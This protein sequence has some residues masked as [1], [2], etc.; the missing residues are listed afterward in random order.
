MHKRR[1]GALL[2][3]VVTAL[4][5]APA[6]NAQA[7]LVEVAPCDDARLSKPFAPWLDVANYKLAP[8]G[9]FERGFGGWTLSRGAAPALGSEPWG[10]TGKVGTRALALPAGATALSPAT[11]VNAGSPTVRFFARSTGG[12]LPLLRVDAVY[13]DGL[14]SVAVP[15]GVVLPTSRWQ[16]S[17]PMLTGSV[18]TA[19]LAGGEVPM[20]LRFTAVRGT[21][22]VDDV[23]VDPYSRR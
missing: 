17:A 4:L 9:D 14:A 19:A 13:R 10:V 23:F 6:A 12:L 20:S 2:V 5:V 8:G 22:Q 18:A 11:C 16:P 3:A 7:S 1:I 21:W 15:V